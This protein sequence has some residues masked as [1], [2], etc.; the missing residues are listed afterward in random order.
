MVDCLEERGKRRTVSRPSDI[1]P[2]NLQR[3][4]VARGI[5]AA[6]AAPTAKLADVSRKEGL[7][8][9]SERVDKDDGDAN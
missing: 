7:E 8:G 5:L 2:T 1:V 9:E 6:N 3:V 4:I